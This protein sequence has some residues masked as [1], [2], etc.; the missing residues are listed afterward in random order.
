MNESSKPIT[1]LQRRMKLATQ[2]KMGAKPREG[3]VS[4]DKFPSGILPFVSKQTDR[5]MVLSQDKFKL[6]S[7]GRS[8]LQQFLDPAAKIKD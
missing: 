3:M 8:L 2:R 5:S 4:Q 1:P 6:D 7:M